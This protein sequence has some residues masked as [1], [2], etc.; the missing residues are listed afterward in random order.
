[1]NCA[2]F[3][4]V[5]WALL[6]SGCGGNNKEVEGYAQD[7]EFNP[8]LSIAFV[9]ER[10]EAEV[11]GELATLPFRNNGA[12]SVRLAAVIP[13]L[14][15]PIE[16]DVELITPNRPEGATVVAKATL[17]PQEPCE[18]L[19][20]D[21]RLAWPEG[22]DVQVRATLAGFTEVKGISFDPPEVALQVDTVNGQR[23]G[24]GFR[25]KFCIESSV[26]EGTAELRLKNATLEGGA[27]ARSLPLSKGRC[28]SLTGDAKP[29]LDSPRASH[30]QGTLLA[31]AAEFDVGA[32]LVGT[33][34]VAEPQHVVVQTPGRLELRVEPAVEF[35]PDAGEVVEVTVFAT[36]G[37]APP[38]N[39]PIRIE[40]V[41]YTQVL[42]AAGFTD[43]QGSFRTTLLVPKDTL[44][45]RIDAV[46]GG[47]RSGRT[48][49]RAP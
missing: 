26:K 37:G 18:N 22:G 25:Y 8:R 11:P 24:L 39:I 41:P 13:N 46:A 15:K 2:R 23:E 34:K 19:A 32:A 47:V 7:A 17:V 5:L 49:H 6:M 14:C 48:L 10:D 4:G 1:M 43:A 35:L 45:L 16:A 33:S 31:G 29:L 12:F 30:F 9:K 42:P 36:L 38:Y 20:G 27:D 40:T 44:G 3:A 21:V 28:P